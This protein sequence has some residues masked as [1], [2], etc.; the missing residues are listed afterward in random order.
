VLY[1]KL[2]RLLP[3]LLALALVFSWVPARAAGWGYYKSITIDHTKVDATLTDYPLTLVISSDNDI[4]TV[5]NGGHVENTASGGASGSVTV[6]ADLV[7]GS[8]N[9]CSTTYDHEIETYDATTGELVAHVRIPSLSGSS[10]TTL[11]MCY[12]DSSVTTSQEDVTGV[13][14]SNYV[15]VWHMGEGGGAAYDSTSNGN[16]ATDNAS[17]TG[18]IGV[19]GSGVEL[20]STSGDHYRISDDASLQF[21]T[22]DFT[23]SAWART[24]DTDSSVVLYSYDGTGYAIGL[25]ASKHRVIIYSGADIYSDDTIN[26]DTWYH[27]AGVRSSGNIYQYIDGVQQT[28]TGSSSANIDSNS[29]DIFIGQ[30]Y[31]GGQNW[32]G[33]VDEVRL[34]STARSADWIST[35]YNNQS[36]PSTFYAISAQVP[37]EP[38]ATTGATT[39]VTATGATLNGTVNAND[40]S[41]TVEFEYGT[42]TGYG[43]T[44]TA[45][46][47]P[48][49]GTSD[50]S[51]SYALSGLSA[52]TEYHFRVAATN[53]EGTT[54]GDD[55]TFTT[56]PDSPTVTTDAASSVTATGATLNGTVNA[57][58]A[59]TTVTFEYGLDTSY[60]TTATASESP[61]TGTSNTSVSYA[62]S[63]LTPNTTYHYRVVG[64]S[65]GGTSNGADQTFTTSVA[66]PT[67]ATVAAESVGGTVATLNATVNP[68][69][70]S[71][72]VEFEYGTDTSYGTTVTAAESP[73]TGTSDT[74]VSVELT[75]LTE[76]T[77]YH[78]RV[79]ATN[80]E[81]TANGD[82]ATFTT[83]NE[84]PPT[85]TTDAATRLRLTSATLNGTI[86]PS[87]ASTEVIFE[88]GPDDSYGNSVTAAG[89]PFVG[90][91]DV[92]VSYF[93][94]DLTEDTTYHYRVVAINAWGQ[95]EGADQTFTTLTHTPGDF[96]MWS[97]TVDDLDANIAAAIETELDTNNPCLDCGSFVITDVYQFG[98]RYYVSVAGIVYGADQELWAFA[99]DAEWAGTY[100]L[101]G[102]YDVI[103][104]D[105]DGFGDIGGASDIY[106]FPWAKGKK[107]W[108]G[109]RGL[110]GG[111]GSFGLGPNW[112]AVDWT[113]G[114]DF[115]DDD[116]YPNVVYGSQTA[117]IDYVCKDANNV[118]VRAGNFFYL[119]LADNSDLHMGATIERGKPI[120]ALVPGKFGDLD[121]DSIDDGVDSHCG[122]SRNLNDERWHIHW[123]FYAGSDGI[124]QI[125][126]WMLDI[127]TGS[128]AVWVNV[129]DGTTVGV[130]DSMTATWAGSD[131]T[132]E[133]GNFTVPGSS[134]ESGDY[135]VDTSAGTVDRSGAPTSQ[136]Y[137]GG[138]NIFDALLGQAVRM[139]DA[140]VNRFP[141]AE[142]DEIAELMLSAAA[143]PIKIIYILTKNQFDMTIP[144][145]AITTMLAVY[146]LSL[147]WQIIK[148]IFKLVVDLVSLLPFF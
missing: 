106:Y 78:F 99:E 131:M 145:I 55:Q 115:L 54:Y 81:G 85:A 20:D 95:V 11:Y 53:S 4:R 34:S 112:R 64:T 144:L 47:S 66:A 142:E 13:W 110:H 123:I 143:I 62:L 80:S 102:N 31:V 58:G 28:E 130:G 94:D 122:W 148:Q 67:A 91:D 21:G 88:Y 109:P 60:G 76:G 126:G 93:L 9:D 113:S 79:T 119:H 43:T 15:G 136:S 90:S 48:V 33:N 86:N 117:T 45:A 1:S 97:S 25:H 42:D 87:G 96:E 36:S 128:G 111:S 49:T 51:V 124:V 101:N 137:G 138:A 146:V 125:E 133:P 74:S 46:E 77:T 35:T 30:D 40:L 57:N 140:A 135:S 104:D 59:E 68:G 134:G 105:S 29:N 71:T 132:V 118:G 98:T 92:S 37:S 69:G 107:A 32:D 27:K 56:L 6:P 63:G 147:G 17:A 14:D 114:N 18:M 84:D 41:T 8:T 24:S 39:S 44:V 103:E 52:D 141:E 108:Y 139:R 75:G 19:V 23:V 5:A 26:L 12:G 50:T 89:S 2:K 116:F 83:V 127:G 10:D 129:N 120:G 22:G 121:S 65:T 7:F 82:D 70:A 100:I 61:V 72:T 3:I 73:V 16:D 38:T